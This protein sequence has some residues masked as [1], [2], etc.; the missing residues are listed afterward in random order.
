MDHGLKGAS[1]TVAS[2]DAARWA[3]RGG[4]FFFS[5]FGALEHW[6]PC[7]SPS[8]HS[9]PTAG[10]DHK[11]TSISGT[12]TSPNWPDKYPSKKECTWAVSST[13]GHRVKLVRCPLPS[14]YRHP[15]PLCHVTITYFLSAPKPWVTQVLPRAVQ[16]A[17]RWPGSAHSTAIL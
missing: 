1:V 2:M 17:G 15:S 14:L 6:S 10:C 12:I 9:P 7:S 11:V 16:A 13:P 3:G 5:A 8:H 4:P